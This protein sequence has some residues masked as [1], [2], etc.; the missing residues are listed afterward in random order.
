VG[1]T[2]ERAWTCLGC[3]YQV[4]GDLAPALGADCPCGDNRWAYRLVGERS[5]AGNAARLEAMAKESAE[6]HEREQRERS[7]GWVD[8][9]VMAYIE[10]DARLAAC[11][12]ECERLR[13]IADL[14]CAE[15]EAK[16]RIRETGFGRIGWEDAIAAREAAVAAEVARRHAL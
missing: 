6:S 13:V 11:R 3:D 7:E 8:G 2:S 14:A 5:K 9:A 10:A 16:A 4:P 12:A 1:E 15:H